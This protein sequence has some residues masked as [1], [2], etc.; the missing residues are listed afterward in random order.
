MRGATPA[1][2][3]KIMKAIII[4]ETDIDL[5]DEQMQV[6]IERALHKGMHFCGWIFVRMDSGRKESRYVSIYVSINEQDY[7]TIKINDLTD[8]E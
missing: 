4:N 1:Q 5:S 8:E 2:K 6:E 7:L 3:R